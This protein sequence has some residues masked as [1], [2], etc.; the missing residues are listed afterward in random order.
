[1]DHFMVKTENLSAAEQL[2]Q[3]ANAQLA[4][5]Y[6]ASNPGGAATAALTLSAP[7]ND[8]NIAS[9][10]SQTL[11]KHLMDRA[12]QQS[13]PPGPAGA[14]QH[15]P[16][17][18]KRHFG[19]NQLIQTPWCWLLLSFSYCDSVFHMMLINLSLLEKNF[20]ISWRKCWLTITAKLLNG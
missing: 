11:P 16:V 10:L 6:A 3:Q 13:I 17:A 8:T 15:H 20:C 7:V 12:P 2:Q 9:I 19:C 4:A 14:N 18:G 1:M 5:A